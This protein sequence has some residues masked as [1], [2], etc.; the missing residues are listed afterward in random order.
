MIVFSC[1]SPL[2]LVLRSLSAAGRQVDDGNLDEMLAVCAT[3]GVRIMRMEKLHAVGFPQ[4][5][6]RRGAAVVVACWLLPSVVALNG[7]FRF[8]RPFTVAC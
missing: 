2:V 3:T 8:E 6:Y 7:R 5:C 4:V 1:D